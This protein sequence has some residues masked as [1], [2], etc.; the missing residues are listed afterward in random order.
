MNNETVKNLLI[1]VLGTGVGAICCYGVLK[2]KYEKAMA[3]EVESVR[4]ELGR[5]R[6]NDGVISKDENEDDVYVGEVKT[7]ETEDKTTALEQMQQIIK[8][9]GY[10]GSVNYNAYS[11]TPA[12]QKKE[13][14]SN[15]SD[16]GE[17]NMDNRNH[18]NEAEKPFVIAPEE[19]G[20]MDGYK[21]V[22]LT[23]YNDDVLTDERGKII[24]N[25]DAVVGVD[26]LATFGQ[27]EEDSVFVR[28]PKHKTDYEILADE[29]CY[30]DQN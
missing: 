13:E 29:R 24:K 1:F 7:S 11:K 25:V 20:E 6:R 2:T 16:E 27:Y 9:R 14:T 28:N 15:E 12:T 21:T 18:E 30:Y 17:E 26:S 8:D 4:Q 10:D 3:E 22:S 19:F 23:Y 5:Y